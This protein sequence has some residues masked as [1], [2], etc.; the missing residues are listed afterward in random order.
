MSIILLRYELQVTKSN[1]V[2]TIYT[3]Q[4]MPSFIWSE[5]L[6]EGGGGDVRVLPQQIDQILRGNKTAR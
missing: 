6:V 2:P 1:Q 3:Y 4:Y 5:F